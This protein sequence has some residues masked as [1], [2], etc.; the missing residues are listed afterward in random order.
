VVALIGFGDEHDRALSA[1]QRVASQ[2][3]G[4]VEVVS[5]ADQ[6]DPEVIADR[7]LQMIE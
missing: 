4:N 1:Y 2:H 3:R 7:L 5:F 6:T